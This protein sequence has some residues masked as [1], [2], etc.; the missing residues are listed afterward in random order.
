MVF[1]SPVFLFY[2]F[3]VCLILYF[4]SILFKNIKIS[5]ICLLIFSLLFYSYGSREFLPILLISI[6]LNY[7]LSILI[8]YSANDKIRFKFLLVALI[9]DL[10]LLFVF[11][12]LNLFSKYLFWLS[13]PTNI[14]L[15]IG[16]S[17]Y[18][19]QVM[20]YV[21]DVYRKKVKHCSNIFDF[22]L[23]TM[24]F[25]QLIAG[26]IVRY[27]DIEKEL[28]FRTVSFDSFSLGLKRFMV[29]FIKKILFANAMG[30]I[31]DIAFSQLGYYKMGP[32][33]SILILI[34][35]TM[36]IYLDF[37][38]YSDMAIGIGQIFG[39]KFP[40]NFNMPFVSKS[41]SEFWQRWHM[42]LGTFFRDYVY[43]PLGGSRKGIVRTC[44]NL[45]IVF[46]L[47]GFWHGANFNFL[48][49]G[50]YNAFFLV[51]ERLFRKKVKIPDTLCII[52]T[53]I[54]WNIGMIL[55]RAENLYQFRLFLSNF[56]GEI[57][58]N[59]AARTL[60]SEIFN[61]Y[62]G[63]CFVISLLY[64]T[65]FFDKIKGK[66]KGLWVFN[67]IE[68]LLVVLLFIYAVIEMITNGFNPFIYFRF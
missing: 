62:F 40:E 63:I 38:A 10:G 67:M 14:K 64:L 37:L 51:I 4:I 60:I 12:Y 20:S 13:E 30:K 46:A 18:T 22:A 2:F 55:F 24:L 19:F 49:W 1:S 59:V 5:N 56:L 11:K 42:T 26:P 27:S 36:Q 35:Y 44:I 25:P 45:T 3:P 52:Y 29:G 43:I 21:I 16:I 68:D 50:L 6:I 41:I 31:V 8:E 23:F 47:S 7:I 61:P 48:F 58:L 9:L 57:K 33:L 65:P 54:V 34:C 39:F 15:P 53:F 17:F 28:K 32:L 66:F